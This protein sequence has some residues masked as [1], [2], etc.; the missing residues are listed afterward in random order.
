ESY[1]ADS[2]L[3]I[4]W[5]YNGELNGLERGLKNHNG[6][7][8]NYWASNNHHLS[9]R[10][11]GQVEPISFSHGLGCEEK[12]LAGLGQGHMGRAV[13]SPVT[14]SGSSA[15]PA[16]IARGSGYGGHARNHEGNGDEPFEHGSLRRRL[17]REEG[18]GTV[19]CG[20]ASQ[21]A[22]VRDGVC[23]GGNL[24]GLLLQV[25]ASRRIAGGGREMNV[26]GCAMK[27]VRGAN[28]VMG[29]DYWLEEEAI[30]ALRTKQ[31]GAR[32]TMLKASEIEKGVEGL[33][34]TQAKKNSEEIRSANNDKKDE[35]AGTVFEGDRP[36]EAA[37]R[38]LLPE[39]VITTVVEANEG[40]GLSLL[41][42]NNLTGQ[43]KGEGY[44]DTEDH[45]KNEGQDNDD[46]GEGN[47]VLL[48]SYCIESKVHTY[49]ALL[50]KHDLS[51]A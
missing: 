11:M 41:D 30:H 24:K 39:E 43:N 26:V 1:E 36:G 10:V 3:T 25:E 21:E 48:P 46:E 14:S 27:T 51:S 15:A 44:G 4:S 32:C 19:Q 37:N 33:I 31:G 16:N 29:G 12:D 6:M 28:G 7:R 50:I 22:R 13:T 49:I 45:M 18:I 20:C 17:C 5:M 47:E 9:K 23:D 40:P 35:E 8:D 34:G 38:R 42:D 2:E